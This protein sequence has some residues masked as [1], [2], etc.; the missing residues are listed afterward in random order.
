MPTVRRVPDA[1]LDRYRELIDY[2]FNPEDGPQGDDREIPDRIADRYGVYDGDR[3]LTTGAL[4]EF[5]VRLRGSWT[6][7]GG[8]AAVST[9]PEHRRGGNVRLL[10]REL[11]A[12]CR[13]RGIG[14]TAL[15]PFSHP[16][17]RQF[18]WAIVSKY[19]TYEL[20][21]EQLTAAGTTERGTYWRA[22][23]DDWERLQPANLAHGEGT[24]LAMRRD[25][26]WWRKRVFDRWGETP[27]VYAWERDGEVRGFVVYTFEEGDDGTVLRSYDIAAA[28]HDARRHLWGFLGTHDSQVE[29]VELSLPEETDLL[30]AVS[31]P[32][33][34]ECTIHAGPMIRISDVE[35]ALETCP[36]PATVSERVVFDVSDPLAD[37]NDGRFALAVEDGSGRCESTT[38][39]PDATVD[40]GTL[41]Q[42]LVGY[43]AVASARR[44]GLDCDEPT[45]SVLETLFPPERVG[46]REFF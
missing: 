31:D 26:A 33:E 41:S 12:E 8:V 45:A 25:E 39:D 11:L 6:T 15:W 22:H 9:P 44:Q 4:Y 28:D 13:D 14:V 32:R 19:T 23:P 42:V 5:D 7:L 24:S 37:W 46:L 18:G 30:D 34:V 16:F 10:C 36:Y 21:P 1:D 38:D 3:L 40:V 43:R 17:Y 27:W 29:T 20:P 35:R 2:A